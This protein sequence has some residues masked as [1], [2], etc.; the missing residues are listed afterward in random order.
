ME[1]VQGQAIQQPTESQ[2]A[3]E[4]NWSSRSDGRNHYFHCLKGQLMGSLIWVVEQQVHPN[5]HCYIGLRGDIAFIESN[6]YPS[7]RVVSDKIERLT[8]TDGTQKIEDYDFYCHVNDKKSEDF[9]NCITLINQ[10]SPLG[11]KLLSAMAILMAGYSGVGDVQGGLLPLFAF[12]M[13]VHVHEFLPDDAI[14]IICLLFIQSSGIEFDD[15]NSVEYYRE[16]IAK[17]LQEPENKTVTVSQNN[18]N[19]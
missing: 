14:G 4:E 12:A 11:E 8:A 2:S 1:G 9:V 13:G 3:E 15:E 18:N 5:R 16:L 10:H 6:L 17:G 19:G 7:I